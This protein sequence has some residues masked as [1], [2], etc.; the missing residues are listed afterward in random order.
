MSVRDLLL[1]AIFAIALP[2]A[3]KHAYIGVLLWTWVGV[4]NPHRLTWGFMFE[5]PIALMVA[6]F[7]LV[8]LVTTVDRVKFEWSPPLVWVFLFVAWICITTA[9]AFYVSEAVWYLERVLKIQLMT[10]IAVAVLYKKLH[11]RLFIWVNVLSLGFFGVKGGL[12]TIATGGGGRV[13]GPPGGFIQGN[14]ELALALIMG[15]PLMY[16][17]RQTTPYP[18]VR[19][20]LTLMMALSAVGAVG[21]QSR[22]ALLAIAAIGGVLWL[23]SSHRFVTGF[24]LALLAIS[25]WNFM[26]QSWHERMSTIQTFEEDGSAMGR[27]NAWET[28]INIAN[29]RLLGAGFEMYSPEVFMRYAPNPDEQRAVD[30][31]IARAA[32]SIYFQ[33]L[34]EHGYIGLLLFL[35]IWWSAWRV[36][37]GLRRAGSGPPEEAWLAQLGAMAQVSLVGFAVGGAFLS[38]AYFHLPY[39]LL[40][41]LVV[42]RRWQREHAALPDEQDKPLQPRQSRLLYWIRTA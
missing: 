27:I 15:I 19:K 41:M 3:L 9:F 20:G 7:T 10:F 32:H 40:I 17:L 36:A 35:A 37:A 22:G 26:P 23:R 12:Y 33:V 34:G 24:I 4:M 13:W 2:L 31:T 38:L 21:S 16:F 11:L 14:N 1:A 18:L 8:G 39:N 28:A 25:I 29:D 6:A 30:P 42:A 5:A